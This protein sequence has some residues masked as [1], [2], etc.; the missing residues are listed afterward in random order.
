MNRR[1]LGLCALAAAMTGGCSKSD[2]TPAPPAV[3][4]PRYFVI[5]GASLTT[6]T[7]NEGATNIFSLTQG[8]FEE[9]ISD[10]AVSGNRIVMVRNATSIIEVID[11]Q[12]YAAIASLNYS[13]A[14]TG[15]Y[16][17][18]IDI[19]GN[20]AFISDRAPLGHTIND[21]SYIKVINLDV[22]AQI[23]SIPV[24][25]DEP[26]W[27]MAHVD[28]KL[29]VSASQ[30]K[31]TIFVYDATTYNKLQE[32][33]TA[34][35]CSNM[36][37]DKDKNILA[38]TYGSV[39]RISSVDYSVT[40]PKETGGT[41]INVGYS[42]STCSQAY[43]LDSAANVLYFFRTAPQPAA[44][45]FILSSY[46]LN[47]DVASVLLTT[48]I[49]GET[50]SYDRKNKFILIGTG[51]NTGTFVNM[52]STDGVVLRSFNTPQLSTKIIVVY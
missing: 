44:A 3:T 45:P 41:Y 51:D 49:S 33:T 15:N 13:N 11:R 26:I 31:P 46:D 20:K 37:I 1:L 22:P 28:N 36:T 27:A 6:Y 38:F 21:E 40:S 23:D 25:E 39:T 48:F 52:Y 9:W 35:V 18:H 16:H 32:I 42:Y 34:G 12:T 24:V 30:T 5:S 19:V 7:N 29:F 4:E 14:G 47:T 50:L 43:G 8:T 10:F 17:K 2:H